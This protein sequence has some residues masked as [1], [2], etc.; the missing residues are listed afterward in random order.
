M[1]GFSSKFDVEEK[2]IYF[3][4]L[5]FSELSKQNIRSEQL[6]FWSAPIDL[7]E[8]YQFYL[9]EFDFSLSKE[10]FYNCTLPRFGPQ[11]QYEF[12]YYSNDSSLYELIDKYFRSNEYDPTTLTCYKHLKCSRGPS[13]SCLDWSE[14]CDGKIDC[15]D[16][17]LDEEHCWKLEINECNDNEFRC[18]NG[19]CIPE[20]F[21]RDGK[22]IF[23]CIDASDETTRYWNPIILHSK[24]FGCEGI[25]CIKYFKL[26]DYMYASV[27]QY[28]LL[29]NYPSTIC[30]RSSMYQC[31]NSSKCISIHR[32]FDHMIDC[33]YRDDFNMSIVNNNPIIMKQL[34]KTH[35]Y[36]EANKQYFSQYFINNGRCDCRDRQ[37]NHCVDEIVGTEDS[38][39]DILFQ[40]ICDGFQELLPIII[41]NRTE[42]DETEC[43]EWECDNIYTHCDGVWNCLNGKDEISCDELSRS[44]CSLNQHLCVSIITYRFI[45]LDIHKVN[46]GHLD[47]VGGTDEPIPITS[48]AQPSGLLSY[49][50]TF[51]CMNQTISPETII[52]RSTLCDGQ[53]WCNH[54]DDEKFCETD[55]TKFTFRG[56]CFSDNIK[57]ASDIENFLCTFLD[58]KSKRRIIYFQLDNNINSVNKITESPIQISPQHKSRCHH[59]IHLRNDVCLCPPS[60]YGSDCQYQND[61]ISLA[62]QFQALSDSRQTQF[63]III[64]LID[65]SDQRIIHSYEQINYFLLKNCQT[66]FQ[67]YLLYSTRPKDLTKNYSIQIDFYEKKSL[68]HRGSLL[69]P[70]LFPFLPVYRQALIV[71]I[72]QTSNIKSQICS[73]R[74]CIHGK[75]IKY[76]NNQNNLTYCLKWWKKV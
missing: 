62:I 1:N 30:N 58:T 38:S 40:T 73:N 57:F 72:P 74:Q 3:P 76:S 13:S 17:G 41:Q 26:I 60:S 54:G 27:Q 63:T 14:I 19:Q 18:S 59:G 6:Y 22:H 49:R 61:R 75:C 43:E 71:D 35:F 48:G 25:I 70:I 44:M 11:C 45:C 46:D 65:D 67:F 5:T 68:I 37:V 20:K 66:K 53:N 15:I 51:S 64:L 32:F 52:L 47:C 34:N 28:S 2:R 9:N 8:N 56:I 10:I 42:T 23:D 4:K 50:Y 33:P 31:N 12:D 21:H 36:C 29:L 16:G 24:S 69:F 7:I 39:R 55:Q